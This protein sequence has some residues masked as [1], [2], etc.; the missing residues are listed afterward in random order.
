MRP[1][2]A[3]VYCLQTT[4]QE[5]RAENERLRKWRE[6]ARERWIEIADQAKDMRDT[7]AFLDLMADRLEDIER[8]GLA[9]HAAECRAMAARLRGDEKK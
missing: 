1:S 4:V 2:D 6:I 8:I 7:A 3:E 5:L 9:T